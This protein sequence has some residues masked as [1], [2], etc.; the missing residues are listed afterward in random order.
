MVK[1]HHPLKSDAAVSRAGE[2]ISD[3]GQITLAQ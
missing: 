2:P 3:G 1:K